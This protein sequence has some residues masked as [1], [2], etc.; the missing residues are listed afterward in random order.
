MRKSAG[1]E[2]ARLRLMLRWHLLFWVVGKIYVPRPE[3][4]A[5]SLPA[6]ATKFSLAL[7]GMRSGRSSET[8]SDFVSFL[9]AEKRPGG[10]CDA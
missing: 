5:V 8:L 7:D 4:S 10:P 2:G 6:P 1:W 9:E 3:C